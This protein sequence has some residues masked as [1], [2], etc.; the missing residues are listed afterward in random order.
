MKNKENCFSQN[1]KKNVIWWKTR[2]RVYRVSSESKIHGKW[3]FL[4]VKINIMA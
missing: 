3:H 2:S 4:F 1:K